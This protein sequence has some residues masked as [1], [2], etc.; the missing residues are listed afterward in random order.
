MGGLFD[1]NLNQFRWVSEGTLPRVGLARADKLF[2]LPPH[3][4]LSHVDPIDGWQS[5][6]GPSTVAAVLTVAAPGLTPLD[7]QAVLTQD[8]GTFNTYGVEDCY[9]FH[10]FTLQAVHP[11]PLGSGVTATLIDFRDPDGYPAATLYWIQPVQTPQ[12]L[13]HERL[14][15]VA[16]DA[17]TIDR[18]SAATLLAPT[19]LSARNPLQRAASALQ[20]FLA[21]WVGGTIA[22]VFARANAELLQ[23]GQAEIS[24]ERQAMGSQV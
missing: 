16:A 18:P 3:W 21:P 14:A 9:I 20:G 22:P 7:V 5:L 2:T 17:R 12:G 15:L 6:F 10:G 4:R 23:L 8:A 19:S 1:T 13:Y 11:V 24:Q